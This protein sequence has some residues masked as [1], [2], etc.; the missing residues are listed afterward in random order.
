[1]ANQGVTYSQLQDLMED[2]YHLTKIRISFWS[3]TGEKLFMAPAS[4]NS[5]FCSKLRQIHSIDNACHSCDQQAL[6]NAHQFRNQL[7]RFQC[8]AG[9]NEYVY[10][11]FYQNTLLGYFMY[12]QVRNE[13]VDSLGKILREKL[14]RDYFL[15]QEEMN[16]LYEQLPYADESALLAAGRMM[17]TIATFAYLNGFIFDSDTPLSIRVVR[18][19]QLHFMNPISRSTACEFFNVSSSCLSHTLQ[20]ELGKSF[21]DLL[22]QTRI[23]NVCR[24]LKT[25]QTIN[26][27]AELSGFQSP[28]YMARVFKNIMNCTPSQYRNRVST[29]NIPREQTE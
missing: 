27:A 6:R 12:G 17:A 9:L 24:C 4:G 20:T 29:N 21:L 1:M 19:I 22:N 26:E 5:D 10:P 3:A 28:S 15:N 13:S 14:Y 16:L 2:F 8:A 11:V 25:N 7:Y 18:Y 23:E